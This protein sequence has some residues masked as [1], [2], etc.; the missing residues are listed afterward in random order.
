MLQLL[1]YENIQE[2]S[3]EWHISTDFYTKRSLIICETL[4]YYYQDIDQKETVKK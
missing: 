1:L 4:L 3:T 2:K